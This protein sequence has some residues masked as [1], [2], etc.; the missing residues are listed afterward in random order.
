MVRPSHTL[1]FTGTVLASL[2]VVMMLFP[3][4]GVSLSKDL[5]LYFPDFQEWWKD[6]TSKPD[7]SKISTAYIPDMVEEDLGAPDNRDLS[8]P[9]SDTA[10]LAG[11]DIPSVDS[12]V[13]NF[14]P[15][16]I[17]VDNIRQP[18]ELPQSG[19]KCL[20][21]LFKCLINPDELINV[22]RILHYGDSQIETDRISNYLRYKLQQQFGGS[23]PG[24][25]PAKTP[26]DYKSPCQVVNEAG[27]WK[28]YTIFPKIDTTVKHSRYGVLASFTRFSPI[29]NIPEPKPAAE[30]DSTS[31][32]DSLAVIDMPAIREPEPDNAPMYHAALKFIPSKIGHSNVGSIKRVKMFYGANTK[33]FSIKVMDGESLLY[34]DNLPAHTSGYASKTWNFSS[35]PADFRMEFDGADSPEIYA[36]AMDGLSG[37][38][39]DNIALRGCSGT[40][41]TKMNGAF[42]A[43]MYRDLHVKC[44]I[45]QFGGNAV[46]SLQPGSCGGFQK[47]FAA[48]IKYIRRLC[49]DMSIIVIGPADMSRK[50]EGSDDYETYPVLPELVQALRRAA[51]DNDCAY[52]DMYSAMGGINTM[53]DWV[54]HE[55][56][57]AEKD[58]VHFTPNGANVMARMFY[59]S[60]IA[61]Y[62]E[63]IAGK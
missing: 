49:P 25:V 33:P 53:P 6:A 30:N 59:S 8:S 38:A 15:K 26:Y 13:F 19:L 28:R 10:L 48:Q 61:R 40:I 20:E 11:M 51:L 34:E 50:V 63:Y 23:G 17:D 44:V 2:A 9:V 54:F 57:Y 18:L 42:L 22:V 37:V 45:L 24:L 46:P 5:T 55:P 62:N 32:Y 52:W 56:P 7:T 1:V 3:K 41:F 35:T 16:A 39:V 27:D 58:F 47:S 31:A 60:L 43:Q 29:I 12:S 36:F 21:N 4:D 14:V